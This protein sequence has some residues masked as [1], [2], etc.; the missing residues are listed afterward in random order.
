MTGK[1]RAEQ[2][3]KTGKS[4]SIC[5]TK[6]YNSTKHPEQMNEIGDWDSQ[7]RKNVKSRDADVTHLDMHS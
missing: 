1:E 4:K 2:A 5:P 3:P 7:E 6:D